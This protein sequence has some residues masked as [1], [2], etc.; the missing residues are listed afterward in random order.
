MVGG[1]AHIWKLDPEPS[2]SGRDVPRLGVVHHFRLSRS[3]PSRSWA[4]SRIMPENLYSDAEA[5]L[6]LLT[7]HHLHFVRLNVS[8]SYSRELEV[9]NGHY[10]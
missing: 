7:F 9:T 5:E 2:E 3:K 1:E 10:T 8:A 4:L 6:D